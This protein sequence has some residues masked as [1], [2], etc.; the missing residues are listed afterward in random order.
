ME[1]AVG[2]PLSAKPL[3]DATEEALASVAKKN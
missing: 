2:S 1:E 3:I